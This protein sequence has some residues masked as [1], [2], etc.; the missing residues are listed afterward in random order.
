MLKDLI[1]IE[2]IWAVLLFHCFSV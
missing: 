1:I 2:I